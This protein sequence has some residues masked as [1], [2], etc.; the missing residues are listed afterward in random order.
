[1]TMTRIPENDRD[2][3]EQ[4]IYLPM[5]VIILERDL[6]IIEKA[7]FKINRPYLTLVE[8]TLKKV[9]RDLKEVRDKMRKGNMK[10]HQI[11]HDDTFTMFSFLYKGYEEQHNYFNPRLRNKCEELLDFYLNKKD[12]RTIT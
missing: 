4:A 3:I 5:I 2:L 9:Q 1:M 11:S 6:Q 7:P 8:N 12:F 10:V